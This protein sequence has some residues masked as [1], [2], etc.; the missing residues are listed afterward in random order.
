MI[1]MTCSKITKTNS[2]KNI[3]SGQ[4]GREESDERRRESVGTRIQQRKTAGPWIMQLKQNQELNPRRNQHANRQENQHEN[5]QEVRHSVVLAD[6]MPQRDESFLPLHPDP[7]EVN[8]KPQQQQ[9]E[10]RFF[11][12]IN[13]Y[14]YN[15]RVF[16]QSQLQYQI[17]GMSDDQLKELLYE[18]DHDPKYVQELLGL[19]GI[20]ETALTSGGERK[21]GPNANT[22]NT[23]NSDAYQ[24][25]LFQKMLHVHQTDMANNKDKESNLKLS[26]KIKRG[27]GPQLSVV[28]PL[29]VLRQQLVYEL[30]RRRIKENREKIQINEQLLKTIGKRSVDDRHYYSQMKRSTLVSPN[31]LLEN[32]RLQVSL[33]SISRRR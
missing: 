20:L 19:N 26:E 33:E 29:E 15:R 22:R 24:L 23:P 4:Q 10:A 6:E 14:N 17:Q 8:L 32:Q 16:P 7:E 3:F 31:S 9:E 13:D 27:E 11:D 25:G 28:S 2:P 1:F 12:D 30:A 21:G 18:V 5:Q